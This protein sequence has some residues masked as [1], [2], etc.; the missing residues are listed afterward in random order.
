[1]TSIGQLRIVLDG[2]GHILADK[3]LKVPKYQRSYAWEKQNVK[4]KSNQI[5]FYPKDWCGLRF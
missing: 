4:N 3:R 2:I 5:H 1:M